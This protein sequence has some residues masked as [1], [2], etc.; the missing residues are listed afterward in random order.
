MVNPIGPSDA[1]NIL[2]TT[3]TN[4]V[5]RA[6]TNE[7]LSK[8]VADKGLNSD[9]AKVLTQSKFQRFIVSIP[10]RLTFSYDSYV[11]QQNKLVKEAFVTALHSSK[12]NAG[13]ENEAVKS[14]NQR[15]RTLNSSKDILRFED[16]EQALSFADD[17]AKKQLLSYLPASNGAKSLIDAPGDGARFKELAAKYKLDTPELREKFRTS[18]EARV[19]ADA[20]DRGSSSAEFFI[21]TN[22]E[23]AASRVRLAEHPPLAQPLTAIL[24]E[25]PFGL[26]E[27]KFLQDGKFEVQ[28]KPD[29]GAQSFVFFKRTNAEGIPYDAQQFH[30]LHAAKSGAPEK[31]DTAAAR[32]ELNDANQ[33]FHLSVPAEALANNKAWEPL[34]KL[35]TS[36]ESP[37]NQWKISNATS[38]VKADAQQLAALEKDYKEGWTVK[39]KQTGKTKT[40]E[41][42]PNQLKQ[43]DIEKAQ[44]ELRR[45]IHLKGGISDRD[46]AK[47][48]LVFKDKQAEVQG[49][50]DHYNEE[51]RGLLETLNG[52]GRLVGGAQFT[53]YT[54]HAKDKSWKPEEVKKYTDFLLK[55][56]NTLKDLGIPPGDLPESDATVPG[57]QYATFRD[58]AIGDAAEEKA[59]EQ[60]DQ[61]FNY[62]KPPESLLQQYRDSPFFKLAAQEVEHAADVRVTV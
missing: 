47:F 12:V 45:D 48:E 30:D 50:I 37:F 49:H 10:K 16:L 38:L 28:G 5:V 36:D 43:L 24:D 6:E 33:K 35:L 4:D 1:H 61:S 11:S 52:K 9:S 41:S 21:D 20:I 54:Q 25:F 57:L 19:Y 2:V 56:E 15:I 22:A 62:Q 40:Y 44:L 31:A 34:H 18:L 60:G 14:L 27:E 23:A 59:Q 53:L 39:N 7:A 26:T 29:H 3:A 58:E 55:L 46:F 13:F 8:L 51:R 42:I 32:G 17:S